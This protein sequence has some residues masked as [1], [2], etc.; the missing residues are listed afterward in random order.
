MFQELGVLASFNAL[1]LVGIFFVNLLNIV[2]VPGSVGIVDIQAFA[3]ECFHLLDFLR[4]RHWRLKLLI[5]I[6][7]MWLQVIAQKQ[8]RAVLHLQVSSLTLN[9]LDSRARCVSDFQRNRGLQSIELFTALAQKL[10]SVGDLAE[11]AG[12]NQGLHCDGTFSIQVTLFNMIGKL[13]QIE[14]LKVWIT[15]ESVLSETEFGES[16]HHVRLS[17]LETS[18]DGATRSGVLTFVTLSG[19]LAETATR[20]PTDSFFG[21]AGA[22]VVPEVVN[23]EWQQ[24]L[25]R[26]LMLFKA[27]KRSKATHWLRHKHHTRCQEH[28][29]HTSLHVQQTMH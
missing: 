28:L 2:S 20:S 12:V 16:S 11:N 21:A 7:L 10:D 27:V 6:E 19:S 5:R 9:S 24:A 3:L 13:A 15:V 26:Q 17:A 14:L 1:F 18:G 25:L 23:S 22:W 29:R 8:L 4:G